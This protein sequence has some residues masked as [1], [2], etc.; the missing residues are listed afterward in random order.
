V[1]VDRP[2]VDVILGHV[3]DGLRFATS[4]RSGSNRVIEV[5]ALKNA[6]SSLA[7]AAH[8]LAPAPLGVARPFASSVSTKLGRVS[9]LLKQ[10]S[11]CLAH[12]SQLRACVAPLQRANTH[13]AA[14]AHNLI[15]LAAFGSKSP[16]VFE[17]ELTAALGGG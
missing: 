8:E 2:A 3:L 4:I 16:T 5:T 12:R 13:D 9:G 17:H 14:L 10:A 6:S 15:S 1:Q 11:G 7:I